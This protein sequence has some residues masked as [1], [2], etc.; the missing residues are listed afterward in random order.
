MPQLT[1][2]CGARAH[3]R[4]SEA[5]MDEQLQSGVKNLISSTQASA[6]AARGLAAAAA[7]VR[8]APSRS[9]S[10]K[11][12]AWRRTHALIMQQAPDVSPPAREAVLQQADAHPRRARVEP[13][14]GQDLAE[15]AGHHQLG[16]ART[17]SGSLARRQAQHRR[18][19]VDD[20]RALPRDAPGLQRLED[21]RPPLVVAEVRRL[22]LEAMQAH[23]AA[24]LGVGRGL[25][26]V[27]DVKLVRADARRAREEGVDLLLQVGRL[28]EGAAVHVG[29]GVEEGGE[30][31]RL[32]VVDVRHADGRQH[33]PADGAVR[34]PPRR[35]ALGALDGGA[36]WAAAQRDAAGQAG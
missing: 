12:K 14:L 5:R 10:G 13:L 7:R 11:T 16:P 33:G 28:A 6:A 8:A 21:V 32:A 29:R 1:M 20:V 36:A 18:V 23:A 34:W 3:R 30:D 24:A 26:V 17:G 25:L 15:L 2:I 9:R 19:K 22:A 4:Q 27:D 35:P 31:D